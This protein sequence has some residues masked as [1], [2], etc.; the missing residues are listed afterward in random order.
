MIT[1]KRS[2]K[3]DFQGVVWSTS[4][5]C[6]IV[7]LQSSRSVLRTKQ[8]CVP[9]RRC[10]ALQFKQQ[11]H[12]I[13]SEKAAPL[14]GVIKDTHVGRLSPQSTHVWFS[15]RFITSFSW[16]FSLFSAS[17]TPRIACLFSPQWKLQL[18]TPV[19]AACYTSFGPFFRDHGNPGKRQPVFGIMCKIKFTATAKLS[20]FFGFQSVRVVLSVDLTVFYSVHLRYQ[21]KYLIE[22]THLGIR[23]S[24]GIK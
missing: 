9:I 7:Y 21:S 4:I 13:T 22:K 8:T 10:A 20:V 12:P 3:W 2:R 6:I 5:F 18:G 24:R 11:K 15:G 23:L 14:G 19:F 17:M 1:Q 16:A